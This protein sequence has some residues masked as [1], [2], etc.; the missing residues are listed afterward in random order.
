MINWFQNEILVARAERSGN[1]AR[2]RARADWSCECEPRAQREHPT[3]SAISERHVVKVKI[4]S[5]WAADGS[6]HFLSRDR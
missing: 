4:L 6:K 3:G 5:V 2:S 1:S